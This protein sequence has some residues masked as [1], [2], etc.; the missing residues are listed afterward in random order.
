[1]SYGYK[2]IRSR[3]AQRKWRRQHRHVNSAQWQMLRDMLYDKRHS[4][5]IDVKSYEPWQYGVYTPGLRGIVG[6]R[7]IVDDSYYRAGPLD[8]W[9]LTEGMR[10]INV[11]TDDMRLEHMIDPQESL[12]RWNYGSTYYD[13]WADRWKPGRDD[14]TTGDKT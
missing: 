3:A 13:N 5:V 14:Y 9:Q 8:V 11:R 7:M 12:K 4:I 6:D 10:Q 2:K 1:V